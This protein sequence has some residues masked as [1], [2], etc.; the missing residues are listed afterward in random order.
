MIRTV[1][2]SLTLMFC[3]VC[4]V[5]ADVIRA[6]GLV[7]SNTVGEV[8]P[9]PLSNAIDQTGLSENYVSG[10]TDYDAFVV[11]NPVDGGPLWESLFFSTT[12]DIDFNLGSAFDLNGFLLWNGHLNAATGL[13]NFQLF[14]SADA[15]FSSPSLLGTFDANSGGGLQEFSFATTN[16]QFVRL[17]INSNHGNTLQT[18]AGEFAFREFQVTAVPEPTGLM[19][20]ASMFAV[21][22]V[23]AFRRRRMV[24]R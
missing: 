12:G 20:L 10:V 16:T 3:L 18:T 21:A 1:V 9:R 22:G 13:N 19:P 8:A 5:E 24:S 2:L 15:A 11:Q 6:P 17:R 23:G 14:S 4:P 7:L